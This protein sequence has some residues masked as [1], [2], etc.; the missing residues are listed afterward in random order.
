MWMLSH[1]QANTAEASNCLHSLTL[2]LIQICQIFKY[3]KGEL[4]FHLVT[5]AQWLQIFI[6]LCRNFLGQYPINTP[7][8]ILIVMPEMRTSAWYII[9]GS[10]VGYRRRSW[11]V[12]RCLLT[13]SKDLEHYFNPM[14]NKILQKYRKHTYWPIILDLINRSI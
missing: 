12:S 8:Y 7:Q 14:W 6:E 9:T 11:F 2:I 4:V 13:R 5:P 1:C 10:I 3:F